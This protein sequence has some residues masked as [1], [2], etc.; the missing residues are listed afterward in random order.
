MRP[1][2]NRCS[3]K[4]QQE[5]ADALFRDFVKMVGLLGL[6]DPRTTDVRRAWQQAEQILAQRLKLEVG[7]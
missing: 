1:M 7:Q 6:D 2:Q 3:F 5:N 4:Q